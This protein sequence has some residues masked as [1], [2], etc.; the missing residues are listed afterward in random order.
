MASHRPRFPG[1]APQKQR[2]PKTPGR[3][4]PASFIADDILT[5]IGQT[6]P[7]I[8]PLPDQYRDGKRCTV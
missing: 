3:R 8:P 6:V 2:S 7:G 1:Y 5:R 4:P